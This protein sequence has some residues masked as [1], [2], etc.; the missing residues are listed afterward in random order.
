MPAE[1]APNLC[2]AVSLCVPRT[3]LQICSVSLCASA[4]PR[5]CVSV[6]LCALVPPGPCVCVPA[7]LYPGSVGAG[8][9]LAHL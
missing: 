4:C 8:L 1:A 2:K 5:A 6:C 9:S 7:R 3:S